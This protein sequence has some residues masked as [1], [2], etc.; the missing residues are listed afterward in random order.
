M[1]ENTDISDIW[2]L[3]LEQLSEQ[4]SSSTKN[5]WFGGLVLESLDGDV[6][7]LR[8]PNSV[9]RS[10][11]AN[12]YT[13]PLQDA[14]KAILCRDIR[15]EM[16]SGEKGASVSDDDRIKPRINEEAEKY[17]GDEAQ[18]EAAAKQEQFPAGQSAAKKF[19]VSY[20]FDN[21]VV[22]SSNTFAHAA[23]LQV[24]NNPSGAYNPLFIYGPSGV[25]KTHL[26]RAS[27]ALM[28]SNNKNI[29]LIYTR[30]EDFQNQLVDAISHGTQRQFREKFRTVDVLLVDDIQFISGKVSAQEE[31]FNT[32]NDLYEENKQIIL[33]SDCPP[34]KME[35]LENRLRTRFQI[36]LIV[37]IAP[38]DIELRMAII[39]KKSTEFGIQISN[40]VVTFIAD[41]LKDNNRQLE[42]AIK[43]IYAYSLFTGS[44]ITVEVARSA[45]SDLITDDEP[46]NVTID[47][48]FKIV[49]EKY[50]VTPDEIKGNKRNA[51]IVMARHVCIYLLRSLTDLKLK[52]IGNLVG[53]RD[54]STVSS[55]ID[56]IDREMSQNSMFEDEINELV[57]EIKG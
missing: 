46:I 53:G 42:G 37:D 32:F 45:I 36:G 2:T 39:K 55:S 26:M 21:F 47:K 51:D 25:G 22:G 41:K 8:E 28:K 12:R 57:S 52:N 11:V 7:V 4:F 31:F 9:K 30:G 13:K 24:S 18:K 50:S 34:N 44:E 33:T 16:T 43:K 10:I 54:H 40:E 15:V 35:N 48:I 23:S 17:A 49:S 29:N 19:T 5:L 3:V 56:K 1:Y 14:F 6:A 20:T 38:P 27:A